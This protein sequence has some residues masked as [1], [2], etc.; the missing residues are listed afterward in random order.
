M[1]VVAQRERLRQVAGQRLEAAEVPA[2]AF[3][4][5]FQTDAVGPPLV[6]EARDALG[7]ARRF[8]GIVEI[9]SESEDLRIWAV[10]SHSGPSYATWRRF[11]RL[12]PR[13]S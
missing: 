1:P 12:R 4:V 9:R 2:P 11:H 10:A 8:D 7:K 13:A 3:F 6:R 5:E